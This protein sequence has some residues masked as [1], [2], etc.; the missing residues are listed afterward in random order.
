[1]KGSE[2]QA[3]RLKKRTYG[4]RSEVVVFNMLQHLL[5]LQNLEVGSRG[6]PFAVLETPIGQW[7][8]RHLGSA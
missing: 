5:K 4:L 1:M 3:S 6:S 7:I 8:L 2:V